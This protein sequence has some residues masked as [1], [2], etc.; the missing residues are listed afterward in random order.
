M[1]ILT[2]DIEEWYLEKVLHGGR[3]EKYQSYDQTKEKML[4]FLEQNKITATFFCVGKL[5]KEFPMVVKRIAAAGHEVGCHSNE[6]T[7]LTQFD[8]EALR[9]DTI[10]AIDA[11]QQVTGQRVWSYRAPAFSI[12]EKNIWALEVLAECGIKNDSSIFPSVRD[13]GG[14]PS[15]PMDEPCLLKVGNVTM[16]EFPIAMTSIF[17]KKI[18][19]SGGGYFR[20]LPY[21]KVRKTMHKRTYNISYFHLNDIIDQRI[22]MMPRKEYEDYFHENGSLKNRLF[23]YAKSNIGTGDCYG[24]LLHLLHDVP[25]SS[26]RDANI[27][28]TK[29]IKFV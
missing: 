15:F 21:A 13:Y 26:I 23:R 7:W 11:L 2:F 6:H 1:N 29:E 12:T 9:H 14:F 25:F 3:V 10:D 18:A 28:C 17:G 27:E 8:S 4:F 24:K 16:K 5:A 22:K 19:Y 20:M